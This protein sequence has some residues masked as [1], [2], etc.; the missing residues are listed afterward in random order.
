MILYSS[1]LQSLALK[2]LGEQDNVL[3]SFDFSLNLEAFVGK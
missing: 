3:H 2:F 1:S